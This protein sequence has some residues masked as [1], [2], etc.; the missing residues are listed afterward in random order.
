MTHPLLNFI[1]TTLQEQ[2]SIYDTKLQYRKDDQEYLLLLEQKVLNFRKK[3][4]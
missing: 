3:E 4:K 1:E 2:E